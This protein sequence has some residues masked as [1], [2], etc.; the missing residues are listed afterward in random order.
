MASAPTTVTKL[1]KLM[2]AIRGYDDPRQAVGEWKEVYRLLQ[3]TELPPGRVT[4]VVGMRDMPGLATLIDQLRAPAPA[5]PADVPSEETCRKALQAFR[6]R[7]SLTIL[8][9]ESKLGRG[10]LSKGADAAAAIVPPNEWPESVWQEL[11]RQ[12]KLRYIGHGFYE[13]TK[14]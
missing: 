6:K 7:L 13:L 5:A 8:D 10:P 1:D 2:T 14:R 11:V 9:E 3:N 4:G 12:G